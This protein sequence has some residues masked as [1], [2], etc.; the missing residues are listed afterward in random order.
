[1]ASKALISLARVGGLVQVIFG[2]VVLGVRK[3]VIMQHQKKPFPAGQL[4]RGGEQ[5]CL[6]AMS[7]PSRTWRRVRALACANVRAGY[8]L[9]LR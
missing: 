7:G 9:R 1:M 2:S 4:D 5:A 3:L 6:V 8:S